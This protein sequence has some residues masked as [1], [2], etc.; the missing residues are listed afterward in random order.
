MV[1]NKPIPGALIWHFTFGEVKNTP[2]GRHVGI[3]DVGQ[4]QKLTWGVIT[5]EYL[6]PVVY[7]PDGVPI[8]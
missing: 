8:P 7:T 4:H 5:I 3:N 2:S 1:H 6:I